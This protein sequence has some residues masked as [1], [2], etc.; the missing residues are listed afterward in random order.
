[1][2]TVLHSIHSQESRDFIETYK[3]D[4]SLVVD[5]Y[6]DKSAYQQYMLSGNP[7][8]SGF[9]FVVYKG[10]GFMNPESPKWVEDEVNSKH[11]TE[12]QILDRMVI[13][14]KLELMRALD[15]LNLWKQEVKPLIKDN[16]TFEDAW[17]NAVEIDTN[18]PVFQAGFAMTSIDMDT[19]KR[20][21]IEQRGE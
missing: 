12:Q 13:L 4:I 9:P 7:S 21:I 5:W 8:P 18:D 11:L 14:S 20:K 2:I 15:A 1:M 16:E 10:K 3:D 19:V 6:G 17:D